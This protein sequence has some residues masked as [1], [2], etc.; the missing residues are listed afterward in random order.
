[1]G[2]HEPLKKKDMAA[3]TAVAE[4]TVSKTGKGK[5]IGLTIG[6][7]AGVL[8]AACVAVCAVAANSQTMLG[9]TDVLGVDVSGKTRQQVEDLWAKQVDQIC[10]QTTVTVK[11]DGEEA[12]KLSLTE[13][14]ATITPEDAAKTAWDAGHGGNFITN[15]VALVRSWF[16][17]TSVKPPLTIDEKTLKS[18][19]GAVAKKL[20]CKPVDGAYRIDPEKTDGFYVTKPADGR[21]AD[22]DALASALLKELQQ[23]TLQ[24]VEC[25]YDVLAAK[26]VDLNKISKKIKK[27]VNA[28]YDHDTGGVTDSRSGVRFDVEKAQQLLDK[29]EAGKEFVVPAKFKT[30]AITSEKL[31]KVMFRD[32]LGSYT[33]NVGGSA[34]RLNNVRL[35]AEQ[36]NGCVY[37]S[38]EDFYYND[39]VGERTAERGF[40]AAPAYVGGKTVDQVGGGICQVSSTLYYA[41]M[42]SNLEILIREEHQ[43]APSYITFG[44]DATVSWGGPEFAFRNN[45]DYPIKIVTSYYDNTLTVQIYGTK[46]DDTYVQIVSETQSSTDYKVVYEKT[47]DLYEGEEVEEQS[48]YV[49]YYVETWRNVYSGDGELISSTFEDSSN[50]EARDQ[51]IKVGTKKRAEEKKDTKE[52]TKTEK[53]TDTQKTTST[54]TN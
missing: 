5:K 26:G 20:S 44:C 32:V 29:A 51:I 43:F 30:A 15:G 3:A 13:L 54:K 37:N 35:A 19:A 21:K 46:V 9:K 17:Q 6:I 53:N 2:K 14:G 16:Q 28:K 7:I 48:P 31:K 4:K 39:T 24:P 36:I 33:T 18:T 12:K 49:G 50:Y 42:L 45:T 52:T 8:I 40:Q 34:E 22:A 25:R 47:K 41:V 10:D 11:L 1:M 38:G 27:A 23:G